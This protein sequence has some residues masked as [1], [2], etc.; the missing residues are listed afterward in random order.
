MVP[1][2]REWSDAVL[3]V[4]EL[5]HT[6]ATLINAGAVELAA[7]F[8]VHEG[9][10]EAAREVVVAG[11]YRLVECVRTACYLLHLATTSDDVLAETGRKNM[12]TKL[13]E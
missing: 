10:D 4:V 13:I 5:L 1:V 11:L 3:S 9:V 2:V 12:I 7:E 8:A 6:N